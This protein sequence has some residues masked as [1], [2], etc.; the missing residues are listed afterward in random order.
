VPC[1][2]AIGWEGR[3]TDGLHQAA[4]GMQVGERLEVLGIMHE[5]D[6]F[7][8]KVLLGG[9]VVNVRYR[10]STK[11]GMQGGTR[12]VETMFSAI[13]SRIGA[14]RTTV[15]SER[16]ISRMLA[17]VGAGSWPMCT[18]LAGGYSGY[19]GDDPGSSASGWYL[20]GSR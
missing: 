3:L 4:Q 7:P 8:D 13:R 9:K 11:G 17:N 14:D 6:E 5:L 18:P 12:T 1:A 19:G 15:L 2:G 10:S 20:Y 16:S